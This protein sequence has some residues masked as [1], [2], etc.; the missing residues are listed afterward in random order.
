MKTFK[1]V[2]LQVFKNETLHVIE[3]ED[4][5]IINKEDENSTWLLEAYTSKSYM[6]FFQSL[7]DENG[8]VL[9][10]AVI[11]KKDNDPAPLKGKI[12]S[13]QTFDEH[14]SILL[15]GTILRVR[16]DHVE[17]LLHDLVRDGLSGAKLVE[18]FKEKIKYPSLFVSNMEKKE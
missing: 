1:L 10:Q 7:L 14:I 4:G 18:N 6:R 17:R 8:D 5:L 13:I 2:S 9:I 3:L 16:M 15:E 11:T 12:I